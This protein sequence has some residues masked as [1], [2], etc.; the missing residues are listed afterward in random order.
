MR[1]IYSDGDSVTPRFFPG[2]LL[3]GRFDVQIGKGPQLGLQ[4]SADLLCQL[5]AP[6]ALFELRNAGPDIGANGGARVLSGLIL[7][8]D[9]PRYRP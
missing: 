7:E 3:N 1:L 8:D 5:I 6:L 9:D 4:K 2:N